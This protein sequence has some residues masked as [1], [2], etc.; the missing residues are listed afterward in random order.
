[1]G[2]ILTDSQ[3]VSLAIQPVDKA[4]NPAPVEGVAW[5]S[6]D[7]TVLVVT[8]A[9]DGLSAV[10]A[11]TGKIGTAQVNVTADALIGE[12]IAEITGVLDVEVKAGQAVALNISAGAPGE[13]PTA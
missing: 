1:M 11:S 7:V 4:G 6:S 12:G 2:L 9:D 5:T 8:A 3:Q 10:A 13:K